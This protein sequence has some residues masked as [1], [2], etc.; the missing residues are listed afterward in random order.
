MPA[1]SVSLEV[2]ALVCCCACLLEVYALVCSL[3]NNFVSACSVSLEVYGWYGSEY[4]A[5]RGN[6]G[7]LS[8]IEPPSIDY[9]FYTHLTSA[10]GAAIND[11]RFQ[12]FS[13]GVTVDETTPEPSTPGL[14]PIILIGIGCGVV[15]VALC[16]ILII[17]IVCVVGRRRNDPRTKKR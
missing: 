8:N 12:D 2:Y 5:A 13:F 1:C 7:E 3:K 15:V 14:D 9:I 17:V 10:V 6:Y 11:N 4:N 16:V